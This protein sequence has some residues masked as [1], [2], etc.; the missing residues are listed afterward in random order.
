[1]KRNQCSRAG[2]TLPEIVAPIY[3]AMKTIRNLLLT[4]VL[5]VACTA[6]SAQAQIYSANAVGLYQFPF[7]AGSDLAGQTEANGRTWAAAG[8]VGPLIT[9]APNSLVVPAL[10]SPVGNRARLAGVNG[11]A[12]RIGLDTNENSGPLYYSLALRVAD[13][14][15]LGPN[16]G[17]LTALNDATGPSP[18]LPA[19]LAARLLVRAGGEGYQLGL[20]KSSTNNTDFAWDATTFT[21]NDTVFVVA[22]YTFVEGQGNDIA[23]L[24]I[25]PNPAT[26]G[27]SDAPSPTL[28]TS[29]GGDV[30]QLASFVLV[31]RPQPILPAVTFVD[32]V[33]AGTDWPSVTP[34]AMADLAVSTG[35]LPAQLQEGELLTVPI[36]VSNL[37]PD[38]ATSVQLTFGIP[39]GAVLESLTNDHG[40]YVVEGTNVTCSVIVLPAQQSFTVQAVFSVDPLF[41]GQSGDEFMDWDWIFYAVGAERDANTTNNQALASVTV[42]PKLDFGDA[43]VSY[44]VTRAENGA[45]HRNSSVYH[46]GAL[47]DREPNGVHSANAD[48]DDLTGVNDED[49]VAIP[50]RLFAGH[51]HTVTVT[52]PVAGFL[53]AFFDFNNDGDWADPGERV[54]PAGGLAIGPGAVAVPVAVPIGAVTG[55]PH[56]RFRFSDVGGLAPTGFHAVGEV[57]DYQV[58][59]RR[60]DFGNAPDAP[61]PTTL[62]SDGARH[63]VTPGFQLGTLL[64]WEG[65]GPDGL[66]ADEDGV[67]FTTPVT[68][69]AVASAQVTASAA[70]LLD[71]F[72]D[73]NADGDWNDPG[74]RVT[75]AA[76]TPLVAGVNV[77][78]F[79]VPAGATPGASWARFRFSTAG[80]LGPTG[81]ADAGEVE[82]YAVT[83]ASAV[84]PVVVFG[85]LEHSATGGVTFSASSNALA[86]GSLNTSNDTVRIKLGSAGGWRADVGQWAPSNAVVKLSAIG[87]LGGQSNQPLYS[88]RLERAGSNVVFSADCSGMGASQY[89]AEFYAQGGALLSA[90]TP[91]PNGTSFP[92]TLCTDASGH[93][94]L[95]VCHIEVLADSI[96]LWV[97]D[98]VQVPGIVGDIPGGVI[99]KLSATDPTGTPDYVSAVEFAGPG[100]TSVALS[101]EALYQSGLWH[102]AVGQAHIAGALTDLGEDLEVSN[103]D[104]NGLSGVASEFGTQ[105][106]VDVKIP[107]CPC[108]P[109]PSCCATT[110]F[111]FRMSLDGTANGVATELVSLALA[112]TGQTAD[113][114][115]SF[116]GTGAGTALLE[117]RGGG[118]GIGSIPVTSGPWGTLTPGSSQPVEVDYCTFVKVDSNRVSLRIQFAGPVTLNAQGGGQFTGNQLRLD[119]ANSN[120]V[121]SASSGSVT[122]GSSEVA[123]A[124]IWSGVED[125][126]DAPDPSYPTKAASDGARHRVWWLPVPSLFGSWYLGSRP[127]WESDAHANYNATGDDTDGTDDEDGVTIGPGFTEGSTVT[128]TVTASQAGYLDAWIDY[129]GNGSWDDAGE[130]VFDSVH[131]SG[132]VNTLSF[133]AK[134]YTSP[135]FHGLA[136]F[137]RFRF[138]KDGGLG[139][140]GLALTGEVEDYQVNI[141][142]NSF[143]FA[144]M[145]Q[146]TLGNAVA[147][148]IS[149]ELHVSNLGS[150][151]EDGVAVDLQEVSRTAQLQLA[152]VA[153]TGADSGVAFSL[154]GMVSDVP[155]RSLGTLSL[156]RNGGVIELSLDSGPEPLA[157]MVAVEVY[158]QDVLAGSA[159]LPASG[160]LGTFLGDVQPN[161]VSAGEAQPAGNTWLMWDVG[162]L[163]PVSFQ[164]TGSAQNLTGNRILIVALNPDGLPQNLLRWEVTGR[165]LDGL[166]IQQENAPQFQPLLRIESAGQTFQLKWDTRG[167]VLQRAPAVDG[168]WTWLLE[169]T[170]SAEITPDGSGMEFFRL[171]IDPNAFRGQHHLPKIVWQRNI[172]LLIMDDVGVDQV[173]WYANYY[174][175]NTITSDDIT[176][177]D[178][179]E[180]PAVMLPT[181]DKLAAAGVTFLNAWSSPVC[182]PTRACLY[183]GDYSFRHGVYSPLLEGAV[184]EDTIEGA[185]TTTI[186]NVLHDAGYANALFG[187]WH[188]GGVTNK[189]TRP[190]VVVGN[191]PLHFGWDHH[192]G[193]LSGGLDSYTNWTKVVDN[194]AETTNTT[195]ATVDN[196]GDAIAWI[197]GVPTNQPWMVTMAFNAPH[198]PWD[199]GVPSSG[200]YQAR[201]DTDEKAM[202]R[203]LLESMDRAIASLIRT[204][205][206][207]EI[208]KTTI[209][210]IGDN[211][212]P[213]TKPS[214]TAISDQFTSDRL[215]DSL[216]EGGVNVPLIV[217]NGYTYVHPG[218]ESPY[219]E[220]LKGRVGS[221]GRIETNLVQT[222][223]IFTT[224]A[225][226]GR[227]VAGTVD[228]K[229]MVPYLTGPGASPQRDVIFAESRTNTWEP[230]MTW[231]CGHSGW[232]VA[233]R[234]TR[235]K[236]IVKNYGSTDKDNPETSELYDLENDRWETD[237]LLDHPALSFIE[238]IAKFY[239][240]TELTNIL[241]SAKPS[242]VCP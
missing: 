120:A 8:P 240:N 143:P 25:N 11:P 134:S 147:T 35:S 38:F 169:G 119:I 164:P 132:G 80:A 173:P 166:V 158:N 108:E 179:P 175:G 16:G 177:S 6:T 170:N 236:L 137:A 111:A 214:E 156:Q 174:N 239:L 135:D 193:A 21:S 124:H 238:T 233:I 37:G 185:P 53:D 71:A 45:R 215:K 27:S 89:G 12:A 117:L 59:I 44:P 186:A 33:R 235:Y 126:G 241:K 184:L 97:C 139:P 197:K 183:T 43:R 153:L 200:F 24:W 160:V 213:A 205:P 54:T 69:G 189:M 219:Y 84:A 56:A 237:N 76:G 152:P 149:N 106:S 5:A 13:P 138:S 66:P 162:F 165:N 178:T 144:G 192:A 176:M 229:S 225:E 146:S 221:P 72:M 2:A 19:P 85:G 122:L 3:P 150:S 125:Y 103:L 180:D 52:A 29:T 51:T 49:G 30:S 218:E 88:L 201:S 202:Y 216:Y 226:I 64:D 190:A 142:P 104:T 167:A 209:I 92:I 83:I 96:Y 62:A 60:M 63:V 79:A 32:E 187:K 31:Q 223:D 154:S 101:N 127:D 93:P 1:M 112:G 118:Q 188:L 57:E 227:G 163:A 210:L 191:R 48:A 50:V 211:G 204:I 10:A 159:T 208:E 26:F 195:F 230:T 242:A 28:T 141:F 203:A 55:S 115:G 217:A 105:N 77:V 206:Q 194:G 98:C 182:S 40:T 114:S 58:E 99:I 151:G 95:L 116:A 155:E 67:V 110:A 74:E 168:P 22:S 9:I 82:D 102:Q 181:L 123:S 172:L 171:Q 136:T 228:S 198:D 90:R 73:F 109:N 36:T 157:S 161:T 128:V 78:T 70:G 129:N 42:F 20:S 17:T 14:G 91:S 220:G 87:S 7:P 39:N 212:T 148:V 65:D 140:T 107:N 130:K 81:P 4:A 113:L 61:Y 75:L 222:L 145:D 207:S 23:R 46:M 224:C 94:G 15:T 234:G 199:P 121:L 232:D 231:S 196:V 47:F 100:T 18:N 133:T 34:P 41:A 68:A 86:I 131:L